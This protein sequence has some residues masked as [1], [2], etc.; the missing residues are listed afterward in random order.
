LVTNVTFLLKL[1]SDFHQIGLGGRR[2]GNL[3][4]TFRVRR[5]LASRIRLWTSARTSSEE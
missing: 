1:E 2:V 4:A 3:H 5:A